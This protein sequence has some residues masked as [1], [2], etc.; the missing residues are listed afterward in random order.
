MNTARVEGERLSAIVE[1]LERR[2]GDD[3]VQTSRRMYAIPEYETVRDLAWWLERHAWVHD[4]G[5]TEALRMTNDGTENLER[6]HETQAV[7]LP[8]L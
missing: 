8:V 2:V 6:V 7:F 1:N 3:V 5:E 4:V